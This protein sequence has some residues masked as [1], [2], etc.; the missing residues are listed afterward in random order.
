MVVIN[1]DHVLIDPIE[2]VFRREYLFQS[3]PAVRFEVVGG[4][5]VVSCHAGL[6]DDQPDRLP[7]QV[8]FRVGEE[9]VESGD[10]SVHKVDPFEGGLLAITFLRSR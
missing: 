1:F 8:T 7:M 2:S 3:K 6:V 4:V 9:Y 10:Y 5:S